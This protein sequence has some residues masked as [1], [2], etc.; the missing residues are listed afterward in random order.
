M[1]LKNEMSP[2]PFNID[3][4]PSPSRRRTKSKYLDRLAEKRAKER[5]ELR[6]A[7]NR[8]PKY[9]LILYFLFLLY[10]TSF[11]YFTK[12]VTF[13]VQFTFLIYIAQI[14]KNEYTYL[15]VTE[16]ENFNE[17]LIIIGWLGL[18]ALPMYHFFDV[19]IKI[20][21]IQKSFFTK[22]YTL[23]IVILEL[24]F[25]LPLTICYSEN[26]YSIYLFEEYGIGKLINPW[27][28]FFPTKFNKSV[29]EIIRNFIVP[30]YFFA[31]MY[32]KYIDLLSNIYEKF[33]QILLQLGMALCI[34]VIFGNIVTIA[35]KIIEDRQKDDSNKKEK[36]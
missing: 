19:G 22:F 5:E 26:F 12:P 7:E 20:I 27:L 11:N 14:P 16:K 36:K 18:A 34:F 4:P 33:F 9:K 15:V 6:N 1:E 24:L 28:V 10:Y 3:S 25:N 13:I 29:F 32:I 31:I 2:D 35:V 30:I 17:I 21:I 23:I 8:V